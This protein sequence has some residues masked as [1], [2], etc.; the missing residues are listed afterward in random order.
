MA[1]ALADILT[2][3]PQMVVAGFIAGKY[4]QVKRQWP[5]TGLYILVSLLVYAVTGYV[6]DNAFTVRGI[7]SLAAQITMVLIFCQ[8]PRT[9]GV[10]YLLMSNA[11][12]FLAEIPADAVVFYLEPN[13]VELVYLHPSWIVTWKLLFLP[14]VVVSH[15]V[16]FWLCR[17]LFR[18]E[19][20]AEI[21]KYL[22]F[23]LIQAFLVIAPMFMAIS[24]TDNYVFIN[25]MCVVYLLANIG[26]DLQLMQTF[27][28]INRAHTLELQQEQTQHMFQA[29]VD[30][31]NQLRD[32]ASATRQLRHDMVN[33]LQ[34]LSILLEDGATDMA[35]EQLS[36]LRET[37]GRTGRSRHTGNPVVDAVI[38][39][40][41]G[42]CTEAGI[43]LQCSGSLPVDAGIKAVSL[44]SVVANLLDN[45]IHACQDLR[46]DQSPV[47]RFSASVKNDRIV[48]CCENP[49]PPDM[50][51][52]N[53]EPKLTLEH[54]WGLSILRSIAAEYHGELQIQQQNEVI[55]LF[56]WL[57]LP[58][59]QKELLHESSH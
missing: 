4:I 39:S 56:L 50:H 16:P 32:N 47:I 21:T 46:P 34:T 36:S 6:L 24:F 33:Q 37:I 41:L 38:E 2:T 1:S 49:A 40:K 8:I 9:H 27:G 17:R 57:L 55:T 43:D 35:L 45:A 59:C 11:C 31:Y 44:C 13:F 53:T 7:L 54:G 42:L 28:K 20:D 25:S 58:P 23:L 51:L 5:F 48:F 12:M 19:G 3:L 30:Y 52:P 22:P 26:L 10:A 15:A 29:Q 14:L 18:T